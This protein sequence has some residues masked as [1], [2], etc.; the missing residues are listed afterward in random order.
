MHSSAQVVFNAVLLYLS[1]FGTRH[2]IKTHILLLSA[3]HCQVEGSQ[4]RGEV[5]QRGEETNFKCMKAE[6]GYEAKKM[7]RAEIN[8]HLYDGPP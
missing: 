6:D 2:L 7:C 3:L 4:G 8:S 5:G 1:C